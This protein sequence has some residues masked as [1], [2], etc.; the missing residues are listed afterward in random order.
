MNEKAKKLAQQ[1]MAE[2][3]NH[4]CNL[5]TTQF[6]D[7]VDKFA[8]LIVNECITVHEDNY[9]VDIIGDVLKKHFGIEK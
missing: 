1:A 6:N 5:Q 4:D 9:G 2:L 7:F 3:A 8:E